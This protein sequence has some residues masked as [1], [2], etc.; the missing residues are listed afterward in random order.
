[1]IRYQME[2]ILKWLFLIKIWIQK[3]YMMKDDEDEWFWIDNEVREGKE[4][5]HGK[6]NSYF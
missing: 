5:T 3:C 1:L 4:N 6:R 2:I